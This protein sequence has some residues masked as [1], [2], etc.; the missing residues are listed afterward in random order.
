VPDNFVVFW[1]TFAQQRDQE[2]EEFPLSVVFSPR[3][4]FR[5]LFEHLEFVFN[6]LLLFCRSKHTA[7]HYFC[8]VL[9]CFLTIF[10]ACLLN[11]FDES[12]LTMN[13]LP[14]LFIVFA[15]NH[16]VDLLLPNLIT[17]LLNE[18][19]F[20]LIPLFSIRFLSAIF[21]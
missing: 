18:L 3:G 21:I 11:G 20:S 8:R 13:C 5:L 6:W 7:L 4:A 19:I 2:N 16:T 15:L 10:A 17:I 14:N 9:L 12:N 1:P